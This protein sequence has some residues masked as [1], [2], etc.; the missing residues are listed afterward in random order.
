MFSSFE[1]W[2]KE[3][4]LFIDDEFIGISYW[5]N[6]TYNISWFENILFIV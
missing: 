4:I 1:F 5:G 6:S 3:N 2:D